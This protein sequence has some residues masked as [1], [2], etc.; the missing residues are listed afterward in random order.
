LAQARGRLAVLL[1]ISDPESYEAQGAWNYLTAR[2]YRLVVSYWPVIEQVADELLQNG[3][4]TG[5]RL[6]TIVLD[7]AEAPA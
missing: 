4:V 2:V 6:R 7:G 1:D 5:D 3:T